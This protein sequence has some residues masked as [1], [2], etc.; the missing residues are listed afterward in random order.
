MC[1]FVDVCI[2]LFV[3]RLLA[4]LTTIQT[5]NLA[6]ILPLTLSKNEFFC[7]FDQIPVTAASLKKLPCQVDFPHISSIALYNSCLASFRIMILKYAKVEFFLFFYLKLPV[8]IS[9]HMYFRNYFDLHKYVVVTFQMEFDF[10]AYLKIFSALERRDFSFYWL[11]L[12]V[13]MDYKWN[14]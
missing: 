12:P 7:F 3:S 13:Y 11:M 14:L 4:T 5:W 2:F 1:V 8:H 10:F 9:L 6:H